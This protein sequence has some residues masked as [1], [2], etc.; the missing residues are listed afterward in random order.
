MT[1]G[2]KAIVIFFPVPQLKIF[3][4]I[5]IRL[6]RELE[7]KLSDRHVLLIAQR[8][9]LKKPARN[10]R[11]KQMRPRSRTLTSVH[12]CIL[13]D[14]VYPTEIVGKRTKVKVDGTKQIKIFLDRKDHTA[15]E[16]KLDTF[17]AAYKKLTGKDVVSF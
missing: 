6:T 13:S 8:R 16:Y 15:L 3:R 2:K 10:S 17:S 9:I 7:K 1:N 5:Q 14:L 11:V 4:K 12:E